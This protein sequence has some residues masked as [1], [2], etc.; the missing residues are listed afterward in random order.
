VFIDQVEDL[1]PRFITPD[2]SEVL[3]TEAELLLEG[4]A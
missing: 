3:I 4:L 1:T 2:P